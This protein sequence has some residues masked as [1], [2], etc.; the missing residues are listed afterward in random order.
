MVESVRFTIHRLTK[1]DVIFALEKPA[2]EPSQL[3]SHGSA[4][5]E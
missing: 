4:S 1:C 5:W 2:S 3:P